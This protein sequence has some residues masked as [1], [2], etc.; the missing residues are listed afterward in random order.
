MFKSK[1]KIILIIVAI[2]ATILIVLFN[3]QIGNLLNI[4]RGKAESVIRNITLSGE[5]FFNNIEND[6]FILDD[7]NRLVLNPWVNTRHFLSVSNPSYY[8]EVDILRFADLKIDIHNWA[9][10]NGGK[11]TPYRNSDGSYYL[12]QSQKDLI[13]QLHDKGQTIFWLGITN[14]HVNIFGIPVI[15]TEL[16]NAID[17]Y[18]TTF[19]ELDISD[20]KVGIYVPSLGQ[21]E[22][23]TQLREDSTW[24]E[25]YDF[26]ENTRSAIKQACGNN[27]YKVKWLITGQDEA[28]GFQ[29]T[30]DAQS[31]WAHHTAVSS[32]DDVEDL[33]YHNTYSV[34]NDPTWKQ[35]WGKF[36]KLAW[37]DGSLVSGLAGN[38]QL[39]TL[40]QSIFE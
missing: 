30:N 5:E 35:I 11:N 27:W 25:Q 19:N 36:Y 2:L 8:T 13:D 29:L 7:Q 10:I 24:Q 21:D 33:V 3:K 20:A 38:R 15:Y 9:T 17:S 34:M 18:I 23:I 28:H 4:F 12:T 14:E 40:G 1:T 37:T 16:C 26:A 22:I 31:Y 32:V 39:T 6:K